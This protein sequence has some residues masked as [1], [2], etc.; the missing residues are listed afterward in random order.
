MRQTFFGL[1]LSC[2]AMSVSAQT[3]ITL[4][5]SSETAPAG[6]WAQFKIYAAQ[7]VHAGSGILSMDFDPTVFGDIAQVAVFGANGDA[8]GYAQVNGRHV[9]AHFTSSSNSAGQLPG[10]P[11][12]VVTVPVNASIAPG[13]KTAVTLNAAT[14]GVDSFGPVTVIPGE[15]TVGGS[16][17]VR[18]I[19][20]GYGLW[21]QGTVLQIDGAGF[22]ASTA[23]TADG[24]SLS[25]VQLVSPQ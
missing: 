12:A 5:V 8:L 14:T 3:P 21:P 6:G 20:P 24:V 22:T 11:I 18:S 23:V 9:D 13:T 19:A 16:L 10:L 1:W 25:A 7:P 15:F 4:Q 2:C 17:S